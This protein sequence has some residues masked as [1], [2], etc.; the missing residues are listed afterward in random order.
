MP[1]LPEIFQMAAAVR[2]VAAG[3]MFVAVSQSD[4]DGGGKRPRVGAP[5]ERFAVD[6]VA[7]GKEIRLELRAGPAAAAFVTISAGMSGHFFFRGPGVAAP[8]SHAHLVLHRED[9][10]TLVFRDPRRFGSWFVSAEPAWCATRGPCPFTEFDEFC[11]HVRA[12]ARDEPLFARRRVC[13]VMLEQRFFNG[14]GNYVRAEALFRAGA[15]P[16][17]TARDVVL[18]GDALLNAVRDVCREVVNGNFEPPRANGLPV[19]ANAAKY[20]DWYRC[21]GKM[22]AVQ[23]GG[24]VIWYAPHHRPPECARPAPKARRIPAS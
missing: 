18:S 7:R 10:A 12:A 17:A 3:H 6:A 9:G 13:E 1:E 16:F 15:D 5:G 20:E 8:V 4:G 22:S 23:L 2:A 24:R 11:A 21:Y 19:P 14:V